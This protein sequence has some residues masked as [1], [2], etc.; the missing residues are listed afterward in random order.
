M[1]E[2][3]SEEQE[4]PKLHHLILTRFSIKTKI[5]GSMRKKDDNDPYLRYRLRLFELFCLPSIQAQ[6]CKDFDWH[7]YFGS[8]T[9]DWLRVKLD[10]WEQDGA[11]TPIF[12]GSFGEALDTTREWV[13][14]N[15][16]PGDQLLTTRLDNDD[17]LGCHFVE[18]L[19]GMVPES[20]DAYYVCPPHGQ[21]VVVKSDN[22][23]DW[24]FFRMRYWANPFM[25]MMERITEEPLQMIYCRKH[26]SIKRKNVAPVALDPLRTYPSW[27]MIL[28]G[29]NLGNGL[30]TKR[31]TEKSYEEFPFLKEYFDFGLPTHLQSQ[32]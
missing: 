6:T 17:A 3:A 10:A 18:Q 11:F 1:P 25:S 7:V 13:R 8:D 14:I 23:N 20:A 26:G 24:K 32:E 30:W 21:Q 31:K 27:M 19:R 12:A 9:P 16:R 4:G 28:H 29:K 5:S 15:G 2:D 22:P